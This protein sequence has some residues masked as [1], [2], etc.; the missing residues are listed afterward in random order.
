MSF[1]EIHQ[2]LLDGISENMALL[3]QSGKYG[4]INTTYTAA[5]VYCVI[6][7]VLEAYTLQYDTKCYGQISLYG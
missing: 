3:V 2:V 1:E 6:K 5:M 4:A 7:F